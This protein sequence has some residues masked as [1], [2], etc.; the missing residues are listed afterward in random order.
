MA[1]RRDIILV[2]APR[3]ARAIAIRLDPDTEDLL[4]QA[5]QQQQITVTTLVRLLVYG[6]V[7]HNHAAVY[8]LLNLS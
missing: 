4:A 5:A 8:R 7:Q 6:A 2:S 3:D 1:Q